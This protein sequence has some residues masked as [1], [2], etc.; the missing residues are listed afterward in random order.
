MED[1]K[2]TAGEMIEY[3][4]SFPEDSEFRINVI[5]CHQER[6]YGF[7]IDRVALITDEDYPVMFL[8]INAEQAVDITRKEDEDEALDH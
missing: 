5:D 3:L 7:P 8:D 1:R 4:Q 6:K 2:I